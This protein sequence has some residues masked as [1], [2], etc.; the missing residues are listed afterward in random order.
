MYYVYL[1]R[2]I[3]APD[4]TYIGFTEDL[5]RRMATHNAGG[6]KHTLKYKPWALVGYHA[7]ANERKAREFEYYLKTGSGQAFAK[8]R[9]W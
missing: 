6:S 9:L 4:Q 5:K 8:K 7:F 3:A 1:I 2:S